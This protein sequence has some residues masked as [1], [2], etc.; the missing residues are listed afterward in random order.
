M[1]EFAQELVDLIIDNVA[2]TSSTA[3]IGSCGRVCRE[4]LP[5]S[6]MHL[7]SHLTLSNTGPSNIQSFSNL[8]DAS[9]MP[10]SPFVRTLHIR[11]HLHSPLPS[12]EHMERL[13]NFPTLR[14]FRLHGLESSESQEL[15][16]L[17]LVHTH[18]PLV[19]LVGAAC[20]SLTR[21]ELGIPTNIPLAVLADVLAGLQALTELRLSGEGF[22]TGIVDS[23]KVSTLK[24]GWAGYQTVPRTDAFPPH[25]HTV[26]I[27]LYTGASLFF[28]WL[29]SHRETPILT[30][31]SGRACA[32]DESSAPIETYLS[33]FGP[34]I[35][36]L[37]FTYC[38][39]DGLG[40]WS[41]EGTR[42]F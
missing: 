11:I 3:D 42:V 37:S 5:R 34:Q 7:F 13:H 35:K 41:F 21:F 33:R 36:S 2:V 23:A 17:Q 15:R 8:A 29:L 1:R 38:I 12:E 24:G 22:Y 19:P 18:V 28:Q 10:I 26:D 32:G 4:W 30:S 25:L 16:F 9:S 31:L 27:V 14:E 20:P 6:R 39:A 40:F